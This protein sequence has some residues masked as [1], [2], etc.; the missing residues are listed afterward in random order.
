MCKKYALHRGVVTG[1]GVWMT[2]MMTAE[3][4]DLDA[5]AELRTRMIHGAQTNTLPRVTFSRSDTHIYTHTY[6][7]LRSVSILPPSLA[8]PAA[9][10]A[11]VL[12]GRQQD[13]GRR[14]IGRARRPEPG[15][16][17]RLPIHP[18]AVVGCADV[19]RASARCFRFKRSNELATLVVV[20]GGRSFSRRRLSIS[21]V[22][23][24][25]TGRPTGIWAHRSIL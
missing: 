24:R 4:F 2:T 3:A 8:M 6:C 20:V 9:A 14:S 13:G 19:V 18:E 7:A 23:A 17:P 1:S 12:W 10:E 5:T 16:A 22:I 11:L 15:A 25:H 21:G